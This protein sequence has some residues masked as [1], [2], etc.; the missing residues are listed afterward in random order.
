MY[1]KEQGKNAKPCQMADSLSSEH[2]IA[3]L[4]RENQ[5]YGDS[6]LFG[7]D[8]GLFLLSP[9]VCP[10]ISRLICFLCGGMHPNLNYFCCQSLIIFPDTAMNLAVRLGMLSC[11]I[12]FILFNSWFLLLTKSLMCAG[13][14]Y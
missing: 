14:L 1:F 11:K 9:L 2:L 7:G 8:F 3:M 10:L 5:L 4:P 13:R 12:M 6:G